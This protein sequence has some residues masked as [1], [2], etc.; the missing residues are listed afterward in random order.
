MAAS[1]CGSEFDSAGAMLRGSLI[2]SEPVVLPSVAGKQ[3][4]ATRIRF[5]ALSDGPLRQR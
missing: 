4:R 3:P 1:Q 5:C 2:P